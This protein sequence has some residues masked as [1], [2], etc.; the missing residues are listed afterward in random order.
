[1]VALMLIPFN[2]DYQYF[3]CAAID[4][5]FDG[6]KTLIDALFLNLE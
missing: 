3:V 2:S 4:D 1:M 5:D 6:R